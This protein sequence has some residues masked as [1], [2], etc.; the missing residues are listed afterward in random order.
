MSI[1]QLGALIY[2]KPEEVKKQILRA[3]VVAKGDRKKAAEELGTTHRTFY[4]FIERLRLWGEI[5]KLVADRD[6]PR[7]VGPARSTDRIREALTL[8]KGRIEPA[9][10]HLEWD[11]DTLYTRIA[12]LGMGDEI[13]AL[14]S[15]NGWR[16]PAVFRKT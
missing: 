13:A 3:I 6:F 5:D 9:A 12:E 4:R 8:S 7:A 16:C 14:C 1:S 11:V 10:A 2:T 15:E